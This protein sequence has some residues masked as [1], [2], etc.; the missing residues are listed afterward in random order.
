MST[1]ERTLTLTL[2]LTLTST[3]LTLTVPWPG[4]TQ[5]SMVVAVGGESDGSC[6]LLVLAAAVHLPCISPVSPLYLPCSSCS[7]PRCSSSPGS[8]PYIS[9]VSPLYLTM[10]PYISQV[11]LVAWF[12]AATL[13]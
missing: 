13:G 4:P 10:S 11:L 8:T 12:N 5:G 2:T 1:L 6:L 9:P 7:P 3:T